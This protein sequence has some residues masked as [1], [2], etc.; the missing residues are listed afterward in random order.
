MAPALVP[1]K[2]M[3]QSM[4]SSKGKTLVMVGGRIYK[5]EADGWHLLEDRPGHPGWSLDARP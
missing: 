4:P 1:T 3:E 5:R 2:T